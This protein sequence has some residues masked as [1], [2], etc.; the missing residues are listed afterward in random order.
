MNKNLILKVLFLE[1]LEY[2]FKRN[3]TLLIN[4]FS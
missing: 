2:L 4:I 1:N 3:N